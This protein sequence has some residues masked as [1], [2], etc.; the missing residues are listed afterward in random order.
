[1]REIII[2]NEKD[3]VATALFEL[4][5]GKIINIP[6]RKDE[7]KLI[8]T[9][10]F[11]HKFALNDIKKGEY[12]FKYGVAIGVA[13]KDIKKGEHVHMHNLRTLQGENVDLDD[14]TWSNRN[15]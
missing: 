1:M 7:I 15:V 8:N 10:N 6:E 11:E 5:L 2:L 14:E 9:I 12:V 4:K 13:Y 3:N